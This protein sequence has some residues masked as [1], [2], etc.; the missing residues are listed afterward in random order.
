MPTRLAALLLLPALFCLPTRAQETRSTIFG[1]VLDPQGA[2]VQQA[3]VTVTNLDTNTSVETA[4]NETGYYEAKLLLPGTYQVSAAMTGFRTAVRKGISLLMDSRA[5]VDLTLELGSV[6]DSV[7]VV[8]EAP[9]LDTSSGS[10][11]RVLDRRTQ[12]GLP[13]SAGS[14]LILAVFAPGVQTSGEVQAVSPQGQ[15]SASNYQVSGGVGGMNGRWMAR[16]TW[17]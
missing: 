17:E 3:K 11:G 9:L 13:A 15:G 6:S 2:T 4:T 14:T 10:S 5:Q 1:R 7:T 8:A 12:M 16:P